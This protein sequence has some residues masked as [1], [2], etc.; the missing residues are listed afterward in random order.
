MISIQVIIEKK[1]LLQKTSIQLE[2]KKR[3]KNEKWT[4]M[5]F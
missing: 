4:F 2:K 5:E 3:F 1:M